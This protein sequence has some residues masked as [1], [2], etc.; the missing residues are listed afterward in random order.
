M[1]C[2]TEIQFLH[3]IFFQTEIQYNM[4]QSVLQM[5][6]NVSFVLSKRLLILNRFKNLIFY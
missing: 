4:Y 6:P 2:G 3:E 5:N 1:L